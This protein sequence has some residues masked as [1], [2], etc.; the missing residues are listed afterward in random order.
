MRLILPASI[1]LA[2]AACVP[3][4][5]GGNPYGLVVMQHPE[6]KQ[7]VSCD[8]AGATNAGGMIGDQHRQRAINSCVMQYQRAGFVPVGG[9]PED[10]PLMAIVPP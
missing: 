8:G 6:T 9:A 2:L 4:P 1:I 10:G 3:H 5:V 7:T